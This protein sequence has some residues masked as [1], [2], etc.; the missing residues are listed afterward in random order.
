MLV[1]PGKGK[2]SYTDLAGWEA[3]L[4]AGYYF[5]NYAG[6]FVIHAPLF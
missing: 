1:S 6:N 4:H 3:I 5:F 2:S